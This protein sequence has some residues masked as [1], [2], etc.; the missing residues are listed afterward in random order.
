VET[1]TPG[2]DL[3]GDRDHD[4][5]GL[6]PGEPS[7]DSRRAVLPADMS[8]FL[9]DLSI[10]LH[11][12]AIYPRDHP[13]LVP[14]LDT[15]A[16]RAEVLLR[17]RPRFAV[18]VARDRLVIEGVVS[19]ARHPLLRG[20]A[21]HL[22]RHHVAAI[23]FLRGVGG[24]ELTDVVAALA[25]NPNHGQGPVGRLP[26]EQAPSW[27][28]VTLHP[29]TIDGLEI[30]DGTGETSTGASARCAD[31]WVGLARAAMERSAGDDTTTFAGEPA[32]VARAINEH[33]RVEAYDQVIV[34]YLLEIAE[35]LREAGGV[36]GAELRRRVSS[37]VSTMHPE[38]LRR[39]LD[40]GGDALGRRQFLQDAAV[41]MAADAVVTLVKSAAE[42]AEQTVSTGF[43]RL[44]TKLA[45]HAEYGSPAVRPLADS[46]LR[47]QVD[48]LIAGWSLPDPTPSDYTGVLD[49]IARGWLPGGRPRASAGGAPAEPLRMVQ[50]SLEIDEETPALWRAVDLLADEG[51]LVHLLDL[52]EQAG[53]GNLAQRV[54]DHVVSPETVR[55]L[56][57]RVPPDLA[58]LDCLLPRLHGEALSP[59]FDLLTSDHRPVRRAI[60]DRLRR[61]GGTC[62][63]EIIA[64]MGDERWYVPRNLLALLA[65]MEHPPADFD[66]SPWLAHADARVRREALRVALR[67][68]AVRDTALLSGLA[69]SDPRVLGIALTA[70]HG[71]CPPAAARQLVALVGQETLDDELRAVA[72]EALARA[73]R[74]PQVLHVLLG[75][76]SRNGRLLRRPVLAPKSA[77]VVAA[78]AALAANWAGDP[79]AA[80]VIRCAVSSSDAEIRQ[81]VSAASK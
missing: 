33:Q 2:P 34:G 68:P 21:E 57:A 50:M 32:A 30:V 48:H 45:A 29:F 8:R 81:S 67:L 42:A 43:V 60:F 63:P 73:D 41:G 38:T 9:V 18:G 16:R 12:I 59:L 52:L 79:R 27:P 77:R 11:R 49:G 22:H 53:A 37:L 46:S 39:L 51:R 17:D 75:V 4:Q 14:V 69:D 5:G 70:T 35:E 66:L 26:K 74:S 40:M 65:E 71:G 76:A 1:A 6:A 36:Y 10:A 31:L 80:A 44:L 47:L 62:T 23:S 24:P 72:V 55:R 15:L 58:S 19:E 78:L 20:L 56:L 13:S 3:T 54:W 61:L 25:E 64:R 28:H 7:A